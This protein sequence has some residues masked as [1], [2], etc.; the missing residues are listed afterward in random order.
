M[1]RG[2]CQDFD[3]GQNI[4]QHFSNFILDRFGKMYQP[5]TANSEIL[6]VSL[7]KGTRIISFYIRY[8][9]YM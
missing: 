3:N 9:N 2:K 1:L 7:Y 4:Y 6:P 5:V 8:H